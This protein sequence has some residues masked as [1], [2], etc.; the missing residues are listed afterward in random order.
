LRWA[1]VNLE[2]R[3]LTIVPQKTGRQV[4][5]EI[6]IPMVQELCS[7]FEPMEK[8]LSEHILPHI[9][10]AY[11]RDKTGLSKRLRTLFTDCKIYDNAQ[12]T[13]SFHSF[14]HTFASIMRS[15]DV[16]EF[17]VQSILG[18]SSKEMTRH[19]THVS[20]EDVEH[21]FKK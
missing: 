18:H 14:R 19:Y 5:V 21:A 10:Q 20:L 8:K 2:K 13:V 12:G 7:L 9:A 11:Q 15:H 17:I 16:S 3:V 4:G 6:Y 1:N